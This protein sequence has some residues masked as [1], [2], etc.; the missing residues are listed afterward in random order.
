MSCMEMWKLVAI[1]IM[2]WWC[3]RSDCWCRIPHP[4]ISFRRSRDSH[5]ICEDYSCQSGNIC[6]SLC[7]TCGEDHPDSLLVVWGNC[8]DQS[9]PEILRPSMWLHFRG[10]WIISMIVIIA[11]IAHQAFTKIT[12]T[13]ATMEYHRKISIDSFYGFQTQLPT[14]IGNMVAWL[15]GKDRLTCPSN[16]HERSSKFLSN[17]IVVVKITLGVKVSICSDRNCGS[18][19]P[20]ILQWNRTNG[21]EY[22]VVDW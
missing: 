10:E 14:E 19:L 2:C 5:G 9:S 6:E 11:A 22:Q 8:Q 20:D 3:D 13:R 12:C 4:E 21:N 16:G 17:S 18:Y 7:H 1:W 15:F